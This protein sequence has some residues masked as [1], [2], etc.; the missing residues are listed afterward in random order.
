MKMAFMNSWKIVPKNVAILRTIEI[1]AK[2]AE[3]RVLTMIFVN[4]FCISCVIFV[5]LVNK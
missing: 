4:F 2:K 5:F 3:T 1:E